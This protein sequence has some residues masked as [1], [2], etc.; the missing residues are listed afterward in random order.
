MISKIR[1]IL[2]EE[3]RGMQSPT[4]QYVVINSGDNSY[5]QNII[6]DTQDHLQEYT[7]TDKLDQAYI[8]SIQEA[9]EFIKS[10][11]QPLEIVAIESIKHINSLRSALE[12]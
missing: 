4:N 9:E 2:I 6:K 12:F 11:E 3:V 1:Q 7:F 10:T 5:V 8:F